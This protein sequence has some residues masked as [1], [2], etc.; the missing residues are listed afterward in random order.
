MKQEIYKWIRLGGLLSFI[1]FILAAGPI[2]GFLAGDYLVKRF[3][4]PS[5][6]PAAFGAAGFLVSARETVRVIRIALK[7]NKEA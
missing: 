3:G 6:T 1:P 4:L 2:A 5:F 7:A